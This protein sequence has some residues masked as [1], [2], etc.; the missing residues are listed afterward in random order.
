MKLP[1]GGF[2][3][4]LPAVL[5][6]AIG[7]NSFLGLL[8][9][10]VLGIGVWLLWR[11]GLSP[12]FIFIF[13]Y[14]WLQAS[15]NIFQGNLQGLTVEELA[16]FGG[17][18]STATALSLVGLLALAFGI[19]SGLGRA[20]A[21]Q[22][23][24]MDEELQRKPIMFWFRCYVIAMLAALAVQSVAYT[25]PVLS[26]P[27]LALAALKWAFFWILTHLA[28]SRA[29]SVRWLWLAAFA[30]EFA[31]GIGGYFSNFKMVIFF[32]IF[33]MLSSGIRFT[34]G[35]LMGLGVLGVLTLMVGIT[36]TAI[37]PEQRSFLSQGEQAQV[38][39]VSYFESLSNIVQ[40]VQKLDAAAISDAAADMVS[41]LSY[42]DFFA[43][44]LIRVP[45]QIPHE[46]GALWADA[47]LRPFMPRLLFE[48]KTAINDSDRTIYY[49][50]QIV[51]TAEQG[52][53]VSLGYMAESY[54]DFGPWVM[55]VPI[56]ALGWLLGRFYR[57]M[58]NYP[59]SRGVM[60][61]GLATATLIQAAYL[62][63]SITKMFGGLV[64]TALIAWLVARWIVPKFYSPAQK[65]RQPSVTKYGQLK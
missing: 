65:A 29:G 41:R 32:T 27:L 23:R 39:S 7:A 30:L 62:E 20:V 60:G 14:Q 28:F 61:T 57:W 15:I 56:F 38:V 46:M 9:L 42:I 48:G 64:V 5:L 63:S 45:D 19:R 37:K 13:G 16:A 17:N 24:A 12:I 10:A 54:I 35:R 6:I 26:Q 31:L 51:A 8:A 22:V 1:N 2:L 52:T 49:S 53:S 50:G 47:V 36:W 43:L 18:V 44:T 33:G 40:L 25:V 34:G 59:R 55:M 4:L 58:V 11:P 21:W 3:I